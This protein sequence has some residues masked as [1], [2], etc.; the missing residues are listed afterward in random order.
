MHIWSTATILYVNRERSWLDSSFFTAATYL[1]TTYFSSS[2]F[3]SMVYYRW[4]CHYLPTYLLAFL[5]CPN[6]G[7]I[8]SVF[9][10][11]ERFDQ[12]LKVTWMWMLIFWLQ[13]VQHWLQDVQGRSPDHQAWR[14]SW[15]H[16]PWPLRRGSS[17]SWSNPGSRR[18]SGCISAA[19]IQ[20]RSREDPLLL[21]AVVRTSRL[22]FGLT[23][24]LKTLKQLKFLYHSSI[25][26][27]DK[28]R[29]EHS[30]DGNKNWPTKNNFR[31][32]ENLVQ[33]IC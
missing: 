12:L 16:S 1:P 11:T 24:L 5:A 30:G 19:G 10:K 9:E 2:I 8:F 22:W 14:V 6:K 33:L 26:K 25:E 15:F 3:S 29:Q 18:W 23:E 17:F 13:N 27:R 7:K 31:S 21:L 32:E 4:S 20:V 28:G